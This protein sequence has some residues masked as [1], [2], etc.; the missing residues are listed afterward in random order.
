MTVLHFARQLLTKLLLSTCALVALVGPVYAD[1]VQ[2]FY[3]SA[4]QLSAVVDPVNGTAVYTYDAVGNLTQVAR[5]A[6]SAAVVANAVPGSGPVGTN[7]VISGTGF[8]NSSNTTVSFNGVAAKIISISSMQITVAVPSGATTGNLV[9]TSP[10][11]TS[12]PFTFAV[13]QPAPT[14][15]SIPSTPVAQGTSINIGGSNFST[16][17]TNNRV[18]LNGR[19]VQVT[20]ASANTLTITVPISSSGPV[21]VETP[22]GKAVSSSNLIVTPP[23]STGPPVSGTIGPIV[24]SSLGG[25][26]TLNFTSSGQLG[27]IFFNNTTAGQYI[28]PHITSNSTGGLVASQIIA[29]D[30]NYVSNVN[31]F[32]NVGNYIKTQVLNLTGQYTIVIAPT[33]GA[34]SVSLDLLNAPAAATTNATIGGSAVNLTNTM[35]GQNMAVNFSG[36][37]NQRISLTFMQLSGSGCGIIEI[38]YPNNGAILWPP[39]ASGPPINGFCGSGQTISTGLVELPVAGSYTA[40]MLTSDTTS[41]FVG[42]ASFQIASVPAGQAPRAEL[43][44][45]ATKSNAARQATLTTTAQDRTVR[46]TFKGIAGGDAAVT[47]NATDVAPADGDFYVTILEPDGHTILRGDESSGVDYA[48]G[49]LH[50]PTSGVYTVLVT[51]ADSAIGTY[52]IGVQTP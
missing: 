10:S 28:N 2:Y 41:D 17:P 21:Q 44:S 51:P 42:S 16:N 36:S 23:V 48:S 30:G 9:V 33:G 12:N 19:Y 47:V 13:T 32:Y 22:N 6:A 26:A 31:T 3:D 15:T 5:Y 20:G 1:S 27:L 8:G 11:G 39:S 35:P 52:R 40:Q 46:T 25:S 4:G 49:F 14:I 38:T 7:V 34:G 37:L 18:L 29:P 43:R 50:L 24:T 45:S